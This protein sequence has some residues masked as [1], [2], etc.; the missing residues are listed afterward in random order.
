MLELIMKLR[1]HGVMIMKS[2]SAQRLWGLIKGF[3]GPIKCKQG[4]QEMTESAYCKRKGYITHAD[5]EEDGNCC[6]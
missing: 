5:K 1:K 2:D 3:A 6:N 4:V